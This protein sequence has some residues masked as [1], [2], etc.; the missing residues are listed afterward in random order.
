MMDPTA[1]EAIFGKI[2]ENCK[3]LRDEANRGWEMHRNA[4]TISNF[5]GYAMTAATIMGLV[6][7]KTPDNWKFMQKRWSPSIVAAAT[8][9]TGILAIKR[10]LNLDAHQYKALQYE[11]IENRVRLFE[12]TKLQQMKTMNSSIEADMKTCEDFLSA[13]WD[14]LAEVH[15]MAP[16]INQ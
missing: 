15:K 8:S 16:F 3:E 6:F 4:N 1:K 2:S 7:L 12:A 10:M 11:S 9:F 5:L 14:E 13:L